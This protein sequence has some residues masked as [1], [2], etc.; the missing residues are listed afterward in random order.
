MSWVIIGHWGFS[1]AG[2]EISAYGSL[3]ALAVVLS[4]LLIVHFARHAGLTIFRPSVFGS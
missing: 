2:Y 3:R 4:A 1:L